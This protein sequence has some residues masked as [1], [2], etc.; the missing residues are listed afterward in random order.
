MIN[1][2]LRLKNKATMT[3]LV[4]CVVAFVYQL[5]GILGITTAVS[6]EQIT[7]LFGLVINVLAV[8]GVLVDPTTK[9]VSD[10]ERAME[11]TKPN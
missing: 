2:K 10:S 4:G 11:Y 3:A 7:Q 1:W 9:G 6:E 8:L 5:L